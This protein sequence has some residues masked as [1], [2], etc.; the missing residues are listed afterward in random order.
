[1]PIINEGITSHYLHDD[2][3]AVLL[4][5]VALETLRKSAFY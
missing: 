4:L 5:A 1:M 3:V 2:D